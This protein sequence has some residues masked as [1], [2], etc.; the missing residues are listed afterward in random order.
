VTRILGYD[1]SIGKGGVGLIERIGS[2]QPR[3]LHIETLKT[4]AKLPLDVRMGVIFDRIGA[5]V[6]EHHPDALAIEEQ[7]GVQVG[8]WQR[9]EGFN[10]DNSKTHYAVAAAVCAAR[11]Y[12]CRKV[13][14]L[15]P[16]QIKIGVLGKGGRGGQ[17]QAIKDALRKL[18]ELGGFKRF[19]GDGADA[20]ATAITAERQLHWSGLQERR[21]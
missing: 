10:A 12:G 14:W 5:L 9:E 8:K 21:A 16:Q 13:V 15:T 11:A 1:P 20:V 3:V 18:I 17:K 7:R 6:R 4:E 19:S 2:E